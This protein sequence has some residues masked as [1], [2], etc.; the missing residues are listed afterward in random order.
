ML[1]IKTNTKATPY[2]YGQENR[3]RAVTLDFSEV[4]EEIV[5]LQS[6]VRKLEDALAEFNKERTR[7][8]DLLKALEHYAGHEGPARGVLAQYYTIELKEPTD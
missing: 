6:K 2:E 1:E 7:V 3:G 8:E 4:F 5:T